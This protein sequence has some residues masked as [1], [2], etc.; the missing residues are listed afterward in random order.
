[1]VNKS[2]G[3]DKD[4]IILD[5]RPAFFKIF[6]QLVENRLKIPPQFVRD[7]LIGIPK[8]IIL[9]TSYGNCWSVKVV[10]TDDGDVFLGDDWQKFVE[11]N[12]LQE[13]D[14]LLFHYEH[15]DRCFTVQIFDKSGV[16]RTNQ[17]VANSG[18]KNLD[19][20]TTHVQPREKSQSREEGA[21]LQE[22]CSQHPF[23]ETNIKRYNVNPPFLMIIPKSFAEKHFQKAKTKIR[24][25]NI[26][27]KEWEVN[28]TINGGNFVFVGGW[29]RFVR[30]NKLKIGNVCIF[31]LIGEKVLQVHI[32]D[33]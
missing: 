16:E 23:F 25:K 22:F 27:G 9:E 13:H 29:T 20:H 8:R 10:K 6:N 18:T 5:Q 24:L 14:F 33:D 15:G 4:E 21:T 19:Q 32:S 31:E 7:V 11:D 3:K 26:E 12:L 30:D 1:M 2:L 17:E 28:Y